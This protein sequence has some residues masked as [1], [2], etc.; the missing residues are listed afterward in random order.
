MMSD[1]LGDAITRIRNGN[2]SKLLSVFTNN[3]YIIYS[4]LKV[5]K[6][7][8]YI[9]EYLQV[10]NEK[11][12]NF[13]NLEIK[14]KYLSNGS[15]VIQEIKRLSKPGKRV[16]TKINNLKPYKNGMGIHVLSTPKGIISDRKAIEL[17]VGGEVLFKVF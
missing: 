6:E 2:A 16:Y 8:G 17:K 13:S 11:N 15:P 5:L 1:I 10:P 12:K 4:S 7:E 3:F 14:L 9:K